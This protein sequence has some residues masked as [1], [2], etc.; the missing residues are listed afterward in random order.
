MR[1]QENRPYDEKTERYIDGNTVKRL[2]E[3]NRRR[4]E[5]IHEEYVRKQE[6]EEKRRE[7]QKKARDAARRNQELSLQMNLGY[8]LFLVFAMT[9]LAVVFGCYLYLQSELNGCI[10]QVTALE[11]EALNLKNDND[12]LQKKINASVDL[13]MIR[14]KAIEQ[15]GM[16]YQKEKQ[17]EYFD[18]E[19]NDYMN[20]YEEIPER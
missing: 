20:Q 4:S 14:K 2:H 19:T 3:E 9:V 10:K 8:V 17:I 18:V 13:D 11:T 15:L 7:R 16:I 12:A 1:Q 6:Q 5:Q